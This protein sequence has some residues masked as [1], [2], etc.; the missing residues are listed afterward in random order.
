MGG[1]FGG[2]PRP[3]TAGEANASAPGAT[4]SGNPNQI[5]VES[6]VNLIQEVVAP[7]TW[8]VAGGQA[9]IQQLGSALVVSQTDQVHR[10]I[11]NLLDQLR[12]GSATRRTVSLD[13]RWLL[14]VSDELDQLLTPDKSDEGKIDRHF[15]D[16]LT[17][18]STSLR[19]ATRC[20]S[21]QA[22]Y[23]ISGTQRSFVSSYIPVVG[24]V[25]PP[26]PRVLYAV[27]RSAAEGQATFT[28]FGGEGG[29][30]ANRSV[31]YQ[32]II[33]TPNFGATL[34]VRPTLT[35]GGNDAVVDLRSTVTF[36]STEQQAADA[37]AMMGVPPVDRVA[38]QLQ[39]LATTLRMPLGE[40]ILVG[41]MT[42]LTSADGAAQVPTPGVEGESSEQRQL[43]LVIELR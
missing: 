42:Y 16:E 14:L 8:A 40:P 30:G 43:Y 39:K 38:I 29:A 21:G 17:R 20:F 24:S 37:G 1:G 36:P 6:L 35:V 5:T 33:T 27:D 12:N 25:E 3:G 19:G 18:R 7:D 31:G 32:P 41:G 23:I 34:E 4:S 26:Q 13:A 28:Q 22:V 9:R 2:G 15:L 11:A 10:E